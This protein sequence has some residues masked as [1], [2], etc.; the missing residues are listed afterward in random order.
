M[1]TCIA[2]NM[3]IYIGATPRAVTVEKTNLYMLGSKKKAPQFPSDIASLIYTRYI[4][5]FSILKSR[6]MNS[7]LK[8]GP[9]YLLGLI[10]DNF[11]AFLGMERKPLVYVP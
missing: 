2:I 6:L 5:S 10:R 7:H 8:E 9:E 4:R 11:P 3:C 1:Y